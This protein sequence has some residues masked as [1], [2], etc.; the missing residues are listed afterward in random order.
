MST[1]AELTG[2]GPRLEQASERLG[3]AGSP[4]FTHRSFMLDISRDR[5]PTNETLR[6]LVD[7]LATLR[8]SELQLYTEH[9]F[10]FA[11]HEV[12]WN[13]ASPLLPTEMA[14]LSA[15]CE[16]RGLELVANVNTF[17]HMGRWLKHPEYR[18]RAECPDGPPEFLERLLGGPACL[19]PTED[20][21]EF[22]LSLAREMLA[23][24]GGT[25]INIGADEPFELGHGVSAERSKRLGR[26]A[27][28][29]EH[30]SRIVEPLIADGQEVLFWG[31]EFRHDP[32]SISWIPEGATCVMWTYEAPHADSRVY[33]RIPQA[34]KD[35]LS[36]PEDGYLGF[37]SHARLVIEGE[38]PVWLACGTSSWNTLLGRSANAAGN[39]D[40]AAT[41]G[42]SGGVEGFMLTD[43]GDN[44]HLQPLA[45]SL[46]AIVRGAVASWTGEGVDPNV[47]I[48]AA[49][50]DLLG[51]PNGTGDLLDRLGRISESIGT[52]VLD[53]SA[54]FTAIVPANS[55]GGGEL[56][57][58]GA[59]DA[60]SLLAEARS[61]FERDSGEDSRWGIAAQELDATCQLAD[62]GLRKLMGDEPSQDD[63]RRAVDAQR[64]GWLR[65][66][67]PGGLEDSLA[68]LDL[69]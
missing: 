10:A 41:V 3:L 40:D 28:Y 21:A 26:G 63:V 25:R 62:L 35:F 14:E 8:Y 53:A 11:G 65:S 31:D 7:V 33:D 34:V 2:I 29:R 57:T 45:V 12:V 22:A 68:N 59:G 24:T 5:V 15:Y 23:A 51:A 47:D 61:L 54:V 1:S 44:G 16:A 39:I 60:R 17:G 58:Q 4:Q 38:K 42:A 64:E 20:N 55:P 52:H 32:E 49:V 48:C 19:A 56:D 18:H 46:P 27:V 43:W 50:D 37:G 66:S 36:L 9:T 67:R 30:L 69:P 13:E 6:W